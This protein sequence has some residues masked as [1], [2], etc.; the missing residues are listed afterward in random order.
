MII[1]KNCVFLKK[2]VNPEELTKFGFKTWNEGASYFSEVVGKFDVLR[3]YANTRR[4]V[5]EFPLCTSARIV[6]RYMGDLFQREIVEIKPTYE[7]VA[8][9][10]RWQNYPNSKKARIEE[11]LNKLNGREELE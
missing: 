6:K 4:F 9:I 2:G 5:L 8:I 3:W 10:G 1:K 11:K 7:W